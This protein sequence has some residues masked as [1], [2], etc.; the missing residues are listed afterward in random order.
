MATLDISK[1]GATGFPVK[2]EEDEV[3]QRSAA[4][5]V[6]PT[7]N[8]L[9]QIAESPSVRISRGLPPL[10]EEKEEEKSVQGSSAENILRS[11]GLIDD[12][13]N[14][15]DG[16]IKP[17]V[18]TGKAPMLTSKSEVNKGVRDAIMAQQSRSAMRPDWATSPE[19][20]AKIA[21]T[22]KQFASM[23]GALKSRATS[24]AGQ[25]AYDQ[26]VAQ[27]QQMDLQRELKGMD[28]NATI[29]KLSGGDK[30]VSDSLKRSIL[31][32]KVQSGEDDFGQPIFTDPTDDVIKQRAKAFGWDDLIG[33]E[34]G[35]A[36]EA[37]TADSNNNGIPDL[38]E[39]SAIEIARLQNSTNP[40]ELKRAERGKQI[41]YKKHGKDVVDRLINNASRGQ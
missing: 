21:Q 22:N 25:N 13:D 34:S 18:F 8:L 15:Q 28:V 7:V 32:R 17:S 4:E 39:Q 26:T 2:F 29:N 41:L 37:G 6:S 20:L 16:K 40:A 11:L 24:R 9:R 14:S 12:I 10:E 19:N 36:D 23:R 35:Q 33:G 38:D 5:E 27:K 1:Y 30:G 3:I 31:M